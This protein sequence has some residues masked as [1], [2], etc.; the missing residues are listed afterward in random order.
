MKKALYLLVLCL[1]LA[2]E[3]DDQ[4]VNALENNKENSIKLEYVSREAHQDKPEVNKVIKRFSLNKAQY[5]KSSIGQDRYDNI[6]AKTTYLPEYDV[7]IQEDYVAHIQAGDYESFTYQIVNTY[8]DDEL[9]NLFL[10][11]RNDGSYE[12]Y[13][14]KYPLTEDQKTQI[15]NGI[16]PDDLD[17]NNFE[18]ISTEN[19][20]N[21]QNSTSQFDPCVDYPCTGAFNGT[22]YVMFG[23]NQCHT[24]DTEMV[25]GSW[26]ISYPMTACPPEFTATDSGGGGTGGTSGDGTSTT[27]PD[28]STGGTDSGGDQT[29]NCPG[30]PDENDPVNGGTTSNDGSATNQDDDTSNNADDDEE[31]SCI[32]FGEAINGFYACDATTPVLCVEDECIDDEDCNTSKEDLKKV[33]PN[34]SDS[35]L[36]EI[37]DAINTHGQDFGIDKEEKLQHFLSQA[38]HESKNVINGV[39]FDGL[40]EN[41]NYRVNKLG[42]DYWESKFNPYTSYTDPPLTSIDPNKKNPNDYASTTNS[43]FVDNEDFANFVY[44][45]AN[46]ATGYKLGN[47]NTGDG[48]KFRGR[49]IFQLIGRNNY[50][51]FNAFYQ[52]NYDNTVNLVN[53]PSLLTTDIDIAVI[54]ALWY[55]IS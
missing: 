47:V 33:F 43:T 50:T 8:I 7:T 18:I 48:Y 31:E 40:E 34:V 44:D 53:N 16:M 38:G 13:I 14:M 22:F 11:K 9:H 29:D 19:T 36:Q 45:D 55:V 49:G 20:T 46:R 39:E 4:V 1:I 32:P 41:L 3:K 37:A 6:L 15:A 26:I 24:V 51:D 5:L 52:D 30:C 54:S 10:S 28:T 23:P 2:C 21:S 17:S 42:I 25:N 27:D 35:R 12:V